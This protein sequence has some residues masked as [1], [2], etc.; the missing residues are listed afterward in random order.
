MQKTSNNNINKTP[1]YLQM[2][3]YEKQIDFSKY[4]QQLVKNKF[5][6]K[7]E[8]KQFDEIYK[9]IK[10]CERQGGPYK[11]NSLDEYPGDD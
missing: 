10:H 3:E 5:D 4:M 6:F 2:F 7:S 11:A 1:S 9:H 8:R